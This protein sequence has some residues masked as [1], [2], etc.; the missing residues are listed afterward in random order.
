M[1]DNS[2]SPDDNMPT[3]RG[4]PLAGNRNFEIMRAMDGR[5]APD[6]DPET[7]EERYNPHE[8]GYTNTNL[9]VVILLLVI[10]GIL[11]IAFF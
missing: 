3:P 8:P 2:L 7:M 4:K 5:L 11:L 10:V 6:D 9:L 1:P